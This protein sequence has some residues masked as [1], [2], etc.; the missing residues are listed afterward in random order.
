LTFGQALKTL[1]ASRLDQR[2]VREKVVKNIRFASAG[3]AACLVLWIVSMLALLHG[4][5]ALAQP[6]RSASAPSLSASAPKLG[7]LNAGIVVSVP[8]LQ[9]RLPKS[10]D[11]VATLGPDLMGDKASLFNGAL[12]F[13]HTDASLPGNNA[14][15]VAVNRRYVVGKDAG[16]GAA[17]GDWDIDLP[18]I[19]GT[20]ADPQGWVTVDGSTNRCSHFYSPPS[21]QTYQYY[22]GV[23]TSIPWTVWEF[24]QGTWLHMP[25]GSA[26][27]VLRRRPG[28]TFV[29]ADGHSYPLLTK[30]SWQLRCLPAI[31]NGPGEGFVAISPDGVSYRFDWMVQRGLAPLGGGESGTLQLGRSEYMLLATQVTDRHGNTVSYT[32]SGSNLTRIQSSDGRFI[33]F[34]HGH[35]DHRITSIS[36]GSRTWQ[37][38]YDSIGRLQHVIRPDNSRWTFDLADLEPEVTSIIGEGSSCTQPGSLPDMS[39]VGRIKHPSGAVGEFETRGVIHPRSAVERICVNKTGIR[40]DPTFAKWPHRTISQSLVAKRL[41]GPG[42][43]VQSWTY[44]YPNVGASW[45]PCNPCVESKT[46]TVTNPDGHINRYTFGIRFRVNEGQLLRTEEGWNP[47][48]GAAQ[49]TVTQRYRAS[50]PWPEP[51]GASINDTA[52]HFASRHRPLDQRITNQQSTD[53][54]WEAAAG[55]A[56]FDTQARVLQAN[57]SSTLGY[58]RTEF[59]TYRDNTS[60]WVLGQVA[61]VRHQKHGEPAVLET[62]RTEHHPA[63]ALPTAKY[64]FGRLLAR[65]EYHPDGTLFK[66]FDPAGRA[67]T[68]SGYHRGIAQRVD[69]RDGNAETAAVNDLGQIT[70]YTNEAGTSTLY[71]YD[72]MG[73]LARV[74]YPAEAN[75][76]YHATT[77]THEQI[78]ADEHG[79]A[80]GHWRQIT[81]TGDAYTMRWYDALWRVRLEQRFD[82]ADHSTSSM[83]ESRYDHEGKKTFQSYPKLFITPVDTVS[84]GSHWT[85]D[86]LDRETQKRQTSELGDLR[87]VTEYLPGFQRRVTNPRGRASTFA[88]QAFDSPSEEHISAM[89]APHSVWLSIPRDIYGKP[90]SIT[91]GGSFQGQAQQLTRSY[92]YDAH[93]RLCKTLEPESGATVQGY[94]LAGNVAWRASGQALPATACEAPSAVADAAKISFGYDARD[95]LLSTSYGDGSQNIARSYTPDGLLAHTATSGGGRNTITWNYGYNSRRLLTSEQYTWG[96]PNNSWWFSWAIDAHGNVAGLTDPWGWMGYSPNALGQPKEVSGYASGVSF[97]PNGQLAGYT[98]ANGRRHSVAL[99]ARGLPES[100]THQDVAHLRYLYDNNGNVSAILDDADGA[101]SRWMAYDDLDRLESVAG[102]DGGTYSYDAL[103]NLRSSSVGGRSLTHGYDGK[104]RL[105]SLSGSQNINFSYDANGNIINRGGQGFNFDIGNR[106]M[107]APGKASYVYDGHGRRNLIWYH[108]GT[109]AHQAYT[110]DGKLR[111]GWKQGEWGKRHVYLG[112][113]LI[114][115]RAENGEI[116]YSHTDALGSPVAKTDSGGAVTSRLRYEAYGAA[117]AGSDNPGGIGFTGHVSDVDTGLVY[118]QQRYYDPI[119][120]RFLSVDPVTTDANTGKDFGRYTY[121]DNNPYS[122]VDPDGR[123]GVGPTNLFPNFDPMQYL[124]DVAWEAAKFVGLASGGAGGAAIKGLEGAA[125]AVKAAE[126]AGGATKLGEAA[127]VANA[128][129]K[130]TNTWWV[131]ESG[132]AAAAQSGGKMLAPSPSA[133]QAAAAGNLKPMAA[134]SAAAAKAATGPQKVYLGEGKGDIFYKKELPNLLQNMDKGKVPS[135]EINF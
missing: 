124:K 39:G 57:H 41:S 58:G 113:R 81:R 121:V 44:D 67:T 122:K 5:S 37:Y 1:R 104:N 77:I 103:D 20:F 127:G 87:T 17:F 134:E 25:A 15:P 109:Y 62:E 40:G 114:A 3:M 7:R 22:Q 126:A 118:M 78:G 65:F 72:L 112:D 50:G 64:A 66:H 2:R 97:H 71:G 130:G 24:W 90:S 105:A 108:D 96:D 120:G 88:F 133:T 47:A 52:D 68:L 54:T 95:R 45:A 18:R 29:P 4:G 13:N 117:A 10:A 111:F 30:D 73:R 46:V 135:I 76:G 33:T 32:Y 75:L 27:E 82:N 42:L 94:D 102:R 14:L 85:Y 115:E 16:W 119:A 129:Q 84:D 98:L 131:G 59:T 26:Q 132:Q 36:D 91:R 60:R 55:S 61:S 31:Q 128:A 125:V 89:W 6:A 101:N 19:A 83:V 35:G 93:Q 43:P 38:H 12:E 99:N 63:S 123:Q 49:R 80:P 53:F 23:F 86:A 21:T 56:G 9:G 110:Q 51:A 100:W 70:R 106:L 69:H 116:T 48:T 28:D 11:A 8:F 79:L 34:G 92:V 107:W 74:D